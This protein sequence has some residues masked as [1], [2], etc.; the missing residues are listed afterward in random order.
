MYSVIVKTSFKAAHQLRF[1]DGSA[2]PLH[3]HNWQVTAEVS[4]NE[5][6]N[7]GVVMDFHKL[8]GYLNEIASELEGGNFGKI[9]FFSKKNPSAENVAAFFF[10]KLELKLKGNVHL[11]NVMVAEEIG[12]I[13]KFSK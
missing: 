12:C 7:T 10:E 6:D 2:E 4:S 5:L 11:N 8:K 13:A 9:G 3:E 1:P